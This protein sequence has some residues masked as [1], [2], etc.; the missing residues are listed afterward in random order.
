MEEEQFEEA[1]RNWINGNHSLMDKC[2]VI[3]IAIY[4]EH[5]YND[6]LEKTKR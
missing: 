3:A 1:M 6:L 4:Y 2:E 5:L